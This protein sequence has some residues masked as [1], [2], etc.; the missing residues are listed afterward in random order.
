LGVIALKSQEFAKFKLFIPYFGDFWD[1]KLFGAIAH[2]RMQPA[3]LL[4]ISCAA[5]CFLPLC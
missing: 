2:C 3:L 4:A 5:A 1:A